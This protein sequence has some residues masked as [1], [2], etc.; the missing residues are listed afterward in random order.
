MN[1]LHNII[2]TVLFVAIFLSACSQPAAPAGQ[3]ADRMTVSVSILPQKYFVER[4]A[5]DLAEVNVMVGPGDSPHSYE[6]KAS[7]MTALSKSDLYFSIGV[8]F[9]HAWMDRISSANPD[10]TIIDLAQEIALLPAVEHHHEGEELDH[11]DEDADH[12]DEDLDHEEDEHEDEMDP[13]VWT[14]PANGAVLARTIADALIE[15]DPEHT[16]TYRQ[17][18]EVLLKDIT[19]LQSEINTAFEDLTTRKFMVFHPAWG[20]FAQE[21]GLEQIPVEVAGSE[22]SAAELTG[23]LSEA[24]DENITVIFA[25]PEFS[26]RSADYIA[27]EIGGRVILISPLAEDWLNNLRM[28]AQ[29]FAEE[30]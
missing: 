1:K 17:N 24:K 28:V 26:T 14:S 9:E 25:Q 4:I 29:T 22:P 30:L 3:S 20:Y 21:F 7:Q 6:P 12:N 13:H 8:E 18:L 23:L 19:Q 5:G 15:S 10:M 27:S 2:F 16:D 11:D